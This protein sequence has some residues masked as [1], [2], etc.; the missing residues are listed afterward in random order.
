MRYEVTIAKISGLRRPGARPPGPP[1]SINQLIVGHLISNICLTH[2]MHLAFEVWPAS[3]PVDF[4]LHVGDVEGK[5][6]AFP[7]TTLFGRSG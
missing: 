5:A 6:V 3:N 2:C 7:Y 1:G 4:G